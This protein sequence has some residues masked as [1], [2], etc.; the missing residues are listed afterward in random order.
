MQVFERRGF[1][2]SHGLLCGKA[3]RTCTIS[4]DNVYQGHLLLSLVKFKGMT[5]LQSVHRRLLY[6]EFAVARHTEP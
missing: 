5:R 1:I 6:P 4:A 3:T 2:E